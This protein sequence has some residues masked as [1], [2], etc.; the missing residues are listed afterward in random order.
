M[1]VPQTMPEAFVAGAIVGMVLLWLIQ[2]WL[3]RPHRW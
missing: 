2:R 3:S 1:I